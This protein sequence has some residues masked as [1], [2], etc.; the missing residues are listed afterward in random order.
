MKEIKAYTDVDAVD[1]LHQI[2]NIYMNSKISHDYGTGETYTAV[3]VHTLKRIADNSGTTVTELAKEYV[4]TKGAIS[5]ILKKL[6]SKGLIYRE[7]SEDNDNKYHLYLTDKGKELDS[8]HRAYDKIHFGESMDKVREQFSQDD[9]NLTFSVLETWLN[10][11]RNIQLERDKK[12]KA[13]K[14]EMK[15]Q[16]T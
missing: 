7:V 14:K 8:V 10:I 1:I 12:K 9:I 4:K 16:S 13:L 5:Q 2:S 6:E 11:R 3:E 15:K